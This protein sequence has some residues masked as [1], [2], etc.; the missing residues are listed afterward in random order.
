MNKS[1][2]NIPNLGIAEIS[3]YFPSADEEKMILEIKTNNYQ[4]TTLSNLKYEVTYITD[5][6]AGL[7]SKANNTTASILKK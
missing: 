6:T 7:I 5:S 4:N 3:D 2:T 1:T